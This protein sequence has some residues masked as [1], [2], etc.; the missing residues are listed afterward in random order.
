[1]KIKYQPADLVLELAELTNQGHIGAN[2]V[3]RHIGELNQP[4]TDDQELLVS[5]EGVVM[6]QGSE[7]FGKRRI[8]VT[9]NGE[10][11]AFYV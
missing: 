9:R 7:F 11:E 1:M 8:S 2:A 5:D 3:L 4:L 10:G 6:S